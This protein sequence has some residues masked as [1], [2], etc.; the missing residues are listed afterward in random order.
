MDVP[1]SYENIG[2][3]AGLLRFVL[4]LHRLPM[5]VT[6]HKT[7]ECTFNKSLSKVFHSSLFVNAIINSVKSFLSVFVST[8]CHSPL[9]SAP[10]LQYLLCFLITAPPWPLSSA[11]FLSCH[12]NS[13]WNRL[14]HHIWLNIKHNLTSTH[15]AGNNCFWLFVILVLV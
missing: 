1:Y 3:G 5:E 15:Y 8:L 6:P 10:N 2:G 11:T 7:A 12:L 4:R 14:H 13:N 9:P